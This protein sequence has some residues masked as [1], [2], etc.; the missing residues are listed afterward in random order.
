MQ[1]FF[2]FKGKAP[3]ILKHPRAV[4]VFNPAV[5]ENGIKAESGSKLPV[6]FNFADSAHYVILAMI[7]GVLFIFGTLSNSAL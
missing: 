5:F 6:E 4:K 2:L 3:S 1:K 7:P